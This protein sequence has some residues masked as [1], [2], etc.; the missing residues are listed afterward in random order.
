MRYWFPRLV[1]ALLVVLLSSIVM[2]WW[3]RIAAG[4]P[5]PA[6]PT[7]IKENVVE[8]TSREFSALFP[9]V[10]LTADSDFKLLGIIAQN[11]GVGHALIAVGD[12]PAKPFPTG[13]QLAPGVIVKRV[14][15]RTAILERDGRQIQ[16]TLPKTKTPAFPPATT[17]GLPASGAAAAAVSLPGQPASVSPIVQT[18][19]GAQSNDSLNNATNHNSS[20]QPRN[21]EG[22][23][24]MLPR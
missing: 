21:T 18:D 11:N 12:K 13:A 14:E 24:N 15:A 10:T 23:L 22:R 17:T 20:A 6:V 4:P 2:F 1:T 9:Q 7:L 16:L 8:S 3:L 5:A 19:P